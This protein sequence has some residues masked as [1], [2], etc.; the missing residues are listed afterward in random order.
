MSR[1]P[2]ERAAVSQGRRLHRACPGPGFC[3]EGALDAAA[4]AAE[5]ATRGRKAVG[6][7]GG[8]PLSL[9]ARGIWGESG[10][11]A[12]QKRRLLLI[13]T[14]FASLPRRN[15]AQTR[16]GPLSVAIARSN[17]SCLG[18]TPALQKPRRDVMFSPPHL[19]P[20]YASPFPPPIWLCFNVFVVRARGFFDPHS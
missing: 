13:E 5:T 4:A 17:F 18:A 3:Q 19:P 12:V 9:G 11:D 6:A 8:G 7:P 15:V 2:G 10:R 14:R 1:G 16:W 20:T